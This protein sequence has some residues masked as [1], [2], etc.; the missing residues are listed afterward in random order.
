M[1]NSDRNFGDSQTLG[2]AGSLDE[3]TG[4]TVK[5]V[6][7]PLRYKIEITLGKGG[8]R[9]VFLATDTRLDR[10]LVILTRY[11][12]TVASLSSIHLAL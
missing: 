3:I 2:G 5:A 1:G 6:D 12:Q 11:S 10:K 4:E 8:M 9:E 7:L